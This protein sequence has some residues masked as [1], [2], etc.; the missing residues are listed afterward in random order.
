MC[1]WACAAE[2]AVY[3]GTGAILERA[4]LR[5]LERVTYN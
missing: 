5:P 2:H 4:L 3:A 1:R